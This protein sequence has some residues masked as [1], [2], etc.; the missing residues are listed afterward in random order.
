MAALIHQTPLDSGSFCK[1]TIASE[2]CQPVTNTRGQANN[3]F[4]SA[5]LQ[6]EPERKPRKAMVGNL[7]AGY[8]LEAASRSGG[9]HPIDV[10]ASLGDSFVVIAEH[11]P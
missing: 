2:S 6:P 9:Q 5:K 11:P 4:K 1:A 7:D 3:R 10:R 8:G